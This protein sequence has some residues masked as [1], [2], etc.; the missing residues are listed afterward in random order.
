MNF[1]LFGYTLL[2]LKRRRRVR[3]V[4]GIEAGLV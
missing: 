2:S 1:S 4:E 3:W